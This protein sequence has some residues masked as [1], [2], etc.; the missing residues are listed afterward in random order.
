[1]AEIERRKVEEVDDE[2]QFGPN[3]MSTNE[4][5]D[6]RELQKVVE[7]EV[8]S[9]TSR[10]LDISG[11]IREQMPKVSDLEEEESQPRRSATC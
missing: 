7:Y 10:S 4:E 11:V 5:H 3:E 6:K 8:A 1:M 2:D 9:N